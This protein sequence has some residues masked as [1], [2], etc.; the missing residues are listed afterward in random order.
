MPVKCADELNACVVDLIIHDQALPK[1]ADGAIARAVNELGLNEVNLGVCVRR[2]RGPTAPCRPN[3]S[4]SRQRTGDLVAEL[5][6]SCGANEILK[7][8]SSFFALELE[9]LAK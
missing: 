5:A 8:A 6:E 9:R 7:R 1:T 2:S 3:A 4:I